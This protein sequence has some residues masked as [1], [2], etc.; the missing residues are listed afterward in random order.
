MALKLN[1]SEAGLLETI[2]HAIIAFARQSTP[3]ART[4]TRTAT[5]SSARRSTQTQAAPAKRSS[6]QKKQS[7]SQAPAKRTNPGVAAYWA[8]KREEKA[9]TN[10]ATAH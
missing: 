2:G 1:A 5:A 6:T 9:R 7:A 4:Q 3:Q 8:R 10:G